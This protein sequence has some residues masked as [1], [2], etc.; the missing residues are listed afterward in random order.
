MKEVRN[1]SDFRI[2][3]LTKQ[4]SKTFQCLEII[5]TTIYEEDY[6]GQDNKGWHTNQTKQNWKFEKNVKVKQSI[7]EATSTAST[8]FQNQELKSLYVKYRLRKSLKLQRTYL[9]PVKSEMVRFSSTQ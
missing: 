7:T 3:K 5:F 9:E 8:F 2:L 1:W 6:Y 4:L